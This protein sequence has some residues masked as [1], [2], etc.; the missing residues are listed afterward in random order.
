MGRGRGS[1]APRRAVVVVL[2]AALAVGL[3]AV[4]AHA[5]TV[6]ADGDTVTANNRLQYTE[7]ANFTEHCSSRGTPVAGAATIT[8]NG[9]RSTD[10]ATGTHFDPGATVTVTATPDATAA[11]A[12]ITAG[13][14]T[15]TVPS[16]WDTIG[17][18]FTA[19]LTTTVPMTVPNGTYTVNVAVT[20]P[21][22]D[23]KGNA[24]SFQTTDTYS[25]SIACDDV[26]PT[27][28]WTSAPAS[29]D[30]GSAVDYRFSIADP[31]STSWSFAAGSPSC[32]SGTLSGTPA[33][34]PSAQTGGFTCTFPN[35]PAST[36][37]SAQVTD[38]TDASNTL[39]QAVSVAN[40]APAVAFTAA[41]ASATEGDVQTYAFTVTDPGASDTVSASADCGADGSL[42]AGSLALSGGSGSFRCSFPFGAATTTVS[43]SAVDSDG[44]S[45]APATTQVEIADA[46]LT[47]GA[48][49]VD[50]GIEGVEQAHLEFF[51][52]DPQPTVGHYRATVDWGDGTVTLEDA[53]AQL[54]SG[55]FRLLANDHLYAEAGTYH[56][57][58]TVFDPGGST[59]S[60]DTDA[61]VADAPLTAGTLTIGDGVAGIQASPLTF[62]VDDENPAAPVSDLAA[63]IDW[64]DGTTSAG[65]VVADGGGHF[66][67]TGSHLYATPG[68][69]P[70]D[71][72]VS[73]GFTFVTAS[74]TASVASPALTPGTLTVGG[75]VEGSTPALLTFPFTSPNGSAS[76]SDFAATIDW[77]DGTTS[78]GTVAAA[79]G[80][81]FAVTGSHVYAEE[82]SYTVGVSVTGS[83]GGSA[84]ATG[85]SVVADAPL[86]ATAAKLDPTLFLFHGTTAT[87]TDANP[88]AKASDFHATV[89]WGDRSV[90]SGLVTKSGSAF[91]VLGLHLY[92]RT[93]RYT[94]TTK[95]VDGG[96]S[97][98]TAT[99]TLLVFA[100]PLRGF[101]VIGDR[102]ASGLVTFYG[103]QWAKR[104]VLGGGSAPASFKGFAGGGSFGCHS[105]W[106]ASPGQSDP[107]PGD[108][109]EYVAVLLTDSSSKSG[110]TISGDVVGAEIVH[111]NGD[112]TG[113]VVASLPL[114]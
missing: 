28:A 53:I 96:G 21:A 23:G 45:S 37:V 15:A 97:T 91:S 80:G 63:T 7:G 10:G 109:P 36:S 16:P 1:K 76:A 68:S 39:T 3:G 67:V 34:D 8:F 107:A 87:F 59:A 72:K 55:T 24:L 81:G 104:N 70:V 9:G 11:A 92:L 19:P 2:L 105:R 94:I 106:T 4:I 75:G 99:T 29:A 62:A 35:G 33:I 66:T 17:Q 41:P 112:G 46:P 101:F 12:G 40:V 110:S 38:G 32:G 61:E 52:T 50:G 100:F 27:I 73:N 57:H 13:G 48:F 26:A 5:D 79:P 108:L 58:I 85:T 95:I 113:T 44:A 88:K 74:G 64:G 86:T 22:H 102:S 60:A 82:G 18:T 47:A 93:G 42:V 14:S 89:D 43:V 49:S 84:Q 56:V 31:D 103:S 65:L 90:T 78:T 71:V 6:S 54:A 111:S 20:G 77:G 30:E 69:F 25:V 114:C 83:A 98:T 51:F